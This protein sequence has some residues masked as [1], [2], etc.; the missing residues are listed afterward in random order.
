MKL[1]VTQFDDEIS[2]YNVFFD[3]GNVAVLFGVWCGKISERYPHD[4][5]PGTFFTGGRNFELD[6]RAAFTAAMDQLR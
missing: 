4:R 3:N 6:W 5:K 2:G 1:Y